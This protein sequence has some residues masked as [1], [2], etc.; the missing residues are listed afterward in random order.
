MK[1]K[2]E[3]KHYLKITILTS[4]IL[5]LLFTVIN[6]YEYHTYTTNF[7]NKINQIITILLD[8][9][10][11][12]TEVDLIEILNND[13]NTNLD[14][15]SKYGIDLDNESIILQNNE[16]FS[17]FLILNISFIT[18]TIIILIFIFMKYTKKKD[19]DIKD[20]TNYIEEINRKNYNLKIDSISEDELS[21]LKNELYKITI[22]LKE[23]AENSKKDKLELKKSLEDISHQLKTP[24]TSIL[25]ILDNLID[26]PNMDKDIREDFIR[27]I[28]REITNI[29]FL[30][31]SILKL[32]KLESNTIDFI[33]EEISLENL[34]NKSIKNISLLSDLKNIK[35]KTNFSENTKIICDIKWQTE[36]I[37]NIIKNCIEHSNN[38]STVE[39]ITENNKIYSMITI[40]DN[41]TGIPKEDIP[42][43]FE[44]F[45]KG[46]NSSNE[47]IGIGLALSKSII[48]SNNGTISVESSSKG[49]TFYIKYY[50]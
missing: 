50:K 47:S 24:L 23:D 20:I 5:L 11:N 45:Y 15:L 2:I 29:N 42:H 9:Y 8:K 1:N 13:T 17:I 49:T 14:I 27:D 48:E 33:K 43:I 39:I 21:I 22:T 18:I 25:I 30:V 40:K 26:D 12:L 28:K 7:N 36:A 35:L 41:G 46:K 16:Y 31:Q 34:V 44:R 6:I 37:S 38:N 3:L 10:P 19:K 32:S 4:I